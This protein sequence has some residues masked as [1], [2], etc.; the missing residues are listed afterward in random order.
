MNHE[1]RTPL[2]AILGFSEILQTEL[3][4]KMDDNRYAEYA[5]DIHESGSRL[6]EVVNDILDLS[7][8]EAGQVSLR[9]QPINFPDIVDRVLTMVRGRAMESGV[10]ITTRLA[11]DLPEMYADVRIMR[12]I[13]VNL[14][15]N[16]L[17]FTGRGKSIGIS[18]KINVDGEYIVCVSDEGSGIEKDLM[19]RVLEPFGQA[20]G[21][22]TRTH[23]GV[24][25]GLPLAKSFV[26]M[27][28]G[29]LRLESEV[30]VGT[31]VYLAF[32]PERV[33]N[34]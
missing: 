19:E 33:L 34:I 11:K 20:D 29:T 30:G 16:A 8:I 6:L 32:P 2:N 12:Q 22:F 4:G 25:L 14:V 10:E 21:S 24:G 26:E 1:L 31:K 28:G 9:E 15:S 17:K 7:R 13:L 3:F 5:A 18:A 27:H 23:E